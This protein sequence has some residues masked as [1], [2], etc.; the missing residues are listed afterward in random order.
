MA[1]VP[2]FPDGADLQK[3]A[4]E[5]F[6]HEVA[7]R[8]GLVP[9]FFRSAPDAPFVVRELWLFAK[10]AYLDTPIPT[11]FK[12]RLFVYLSRFCEVRYCITRHCGFLLGLGRSAGDPSAQAM[13]ITQVIRLLQRSIPTEESTAAAL[14]RLEAVASPI[15]WPIP[16]TS[17][18]EDLFTSATVLF[19]QPARAGRAKRALR[20]ALGG[21]KFELL[22]GLLTFI[23]SAH[24]WTLMHPELVLEDDLKN[25]L[26]QHEELARLLSDD[27]DAGYCETGT[28]LFEELESLRD[29]NERQ[30]LE[31]ARHALEEKDRQREL[32][33]K[34]VDH[35]IKNSL[36]IVSSLLHLQANAAGA[37]ASQFHNAAARISAIAAVHQQLHK[38]DY[39]GTVQLDQYLVGLC[40][41]IA[42]ASG[43][44]DRPW[45]LVVDAVP[46]TISN[47]IAVP[48]ALIVN[49][50]LTNAIQHSQP[51]GDGRVIHVRVTSR[52]DDFSVSVSDPGCGPDPTQ[53]AA[54]L[55]TRLVDALVR[56]INA[57]IEKQSLA[58][59]YTVTVT[60]PHLISS[61]CADHS[62]QV[63]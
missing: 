16:E 41:E 55:G 11:L 31:K 13:T 26:R 34:E 45:S 19:L 59:S 56:Q 39:V 50:M 48:L 32:L 53:T 35:R 21:E 24:Y 62:R 2:L 28:R 20:I 27:T 51:V 5:A 3:T 14:A 38:S 36:Q 8:F 57:T 37:A 61:V 23:R 42:T 7:A 49:E 44:P 52:P 33:L 60:V 63:H 40:Q 43:S 54:G 58:E 10:A 22:M 4:Q 25:L 17:Y 6:E 12:E 9:N 29:R 46:L 47:D 1:I 15:D 30:E 18:D